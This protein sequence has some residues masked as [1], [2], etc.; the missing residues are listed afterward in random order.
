MVSSSLP[1]WSSHPPRTLDMAL[2]L[3]II[4]AVKFQ[5][6]ITEVGRFRPSVSSHWTIILLRPTI[7]GPKEATSVKQNN[8][9]SR[10][11]D[12]IQLL[13]PL[14]RAIFLS[15]TSNKEAGARLI[16]EALRCWLV[17]PVRGRR[18]PVAGPDLMRLCSV[19]K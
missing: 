9:V 2:S 18:G 14:P 11:A 3:P 5:L 15:L 7:K 19:P 6:G 8:A 4:L 17:W 1:A 12:P 13:S 10:S 16:F